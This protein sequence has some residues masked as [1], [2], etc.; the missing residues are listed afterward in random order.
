MFEEADETG[1]G[2]A[3]RSGAPRSF[4]VNLRS[5]DLV[6]EVMKAKRKLSNNYLTSSDIKFELLGP[7]SAA[8]M[9]SSKIFINKVMP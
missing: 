3:S 4:V 7:A 2:L 1:E 5:A 6:R 8:C 9:P